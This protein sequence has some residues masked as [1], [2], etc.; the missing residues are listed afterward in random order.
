[1]AK[2]TTII[3]SRNRYLIVPP[4]LGKKKLRARLKLKLKEYKN[5]MEGKGKPWEFLNPH[6]AHQ[7]HE[8]FRDACYKAFV[9]ELVL[10]ADGSGPVN[11]WDFPLKTAKKWQGGFDA[12]GFSRACCVIDK[13]CG[14][15]PG[16]R[17]VG[18]TGLPKLTK[19]SI[20][21]DKKRP[22]HMSD[23]QTPKVA[24]LNTALQ[25]NQPLAGIADA[26]TPEQSAPL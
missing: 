25:I 1:M 13:Y 21:D 3:I 5:R 7:M 26:R 11:A 24:T 15:L 17:T 14:N 10:Q 2:G 18:G 4:S 23:K 22:A 9:L 16:S 12:E 19:A 8:E 20:V 6:F